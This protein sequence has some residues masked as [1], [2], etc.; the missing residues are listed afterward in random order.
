MEENG[1]E[2]DTCEMIGKYYMLFLLPIGC[3]TFFLNVFAKKEK[4][5]NG[6][7]WKKMDRNEE[8]WMKMSKNG[9]KWMKMDGNGFRSFLVI[10]G[11]F[12]PFS[13][14]LLHLLKEVCHFI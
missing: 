10:L 13:I 6:R 12:G 5:K 2:I 1:D 8:K 11:H 7:K 9:G 14:I 3:N 4:S